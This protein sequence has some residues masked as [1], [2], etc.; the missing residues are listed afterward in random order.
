MASRPTSRLRFLTLDPKGVPID[1]PA[2]WVP[3]LVE[4]LVPAEHWEEVRL[5]RQGEV[6]PVYLKRLDGR[7]RVLADWPRSGSG[8]YRLRLECAGY[9]EDLML[10]IR[11]AKLA[12]RLT[13]GC[14]WTSRLGCR[15]PWPSA[16]SEQEP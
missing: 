2:E 1:G 16:H 5:W 12:P 6:L 3:A 13:P 15:S 9:S 10:T 14:Y 8:R 4:V 7:A 11:P